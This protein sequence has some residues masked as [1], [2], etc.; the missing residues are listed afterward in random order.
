[1]PSDESQLVHARGLEMNLSFLSSENSNFSP[2]LGAFPGHAP[3]HAFSG[4]RL[5][6]VSLRGLEHCLFC[7][8]LLSGP[9]SHGSLELLDCSYHCCSSEGELLCC[10]GSMHCSRA[11]AKAG[12]SNMWI[13]VHAKLCR[14]EFA[15]LA[16]AYSSARR[17]HPPGLPKTS[18]PE[19]TLT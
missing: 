7:H 19:M 2:R 9:I 18:E 1:M 11:L 17:S 14:Q 15:C 4:R 8:G 5:Q 10:H 13:S 16:G 6:C 3:Q 12:A